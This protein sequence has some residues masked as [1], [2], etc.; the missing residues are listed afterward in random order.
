MYVARKQKNL[1]KSLRPT[2]I[3]GEDKGRGN[4]VQYRWNC[5]I[6]RKFHKKIHN[7][8]LFKTKKVVQKYKNITLGSLKNHRN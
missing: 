3:H 1:I 6:S 7:E 4:V 2:C 8:K 5:L